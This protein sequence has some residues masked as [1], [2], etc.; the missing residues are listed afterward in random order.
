M[1]HEGRPE[2][3]SVTSSKTPSLEST[4]YLLERAQG[5]DRS[6][7][8]ALV[9]RCLAPLQRFAHGRLPNGARGLMDTDD[10]VQVTLLRT[11]QRLDRFRDRGRG[12]LLAYLRGAVLNQIRDEVRRAT[13]FPSDGEPSHEFRDPRVDPLEAVIGRQA[14]A[15]YED[16]LAQLLPEQ[17][18]AVLLRIEMGCSYQEIAEA[19]GRPSANAARLLTSRALARLV[20]LMRSLRETS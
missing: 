11:V 20:E 4:A 2:A 14:V 3:P 15:V 19:L 18:E 10:L 16:A 7:R 6:A 5:G 13:R 17:Q 12:S 1:S 9:A 8:E